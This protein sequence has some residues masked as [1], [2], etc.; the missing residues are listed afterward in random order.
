[1]MSGANEKNGRDVPK[2]RK[3]RRAYGE[4]ANETPRLVDKEPA[5]LQRETPDEGNVGVERG[6]ADEEDTPAFEE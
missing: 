3:A 4:D 2:R 1:M 5:D 6:A